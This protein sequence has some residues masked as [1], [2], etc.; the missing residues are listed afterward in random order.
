MFHVFQFLNR[1]GTLTA[2][3][4]DEQRKI[5]RINDLNGNL[6]PRKIYFI[7][8]KIP[9]LLKNMSDTSL[10]LHAIYSSSLVD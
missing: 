8:G 7:R 9:P 3:R 10:S 6:I 2:G 1:F 5:I 4:L